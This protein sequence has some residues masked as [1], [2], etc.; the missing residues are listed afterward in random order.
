MNHVSHPLTTIILMLL[1]L[2]SL[3]ASVTSILRLRRADEEPPRIA[4]DLQPWLVGLTGVGAAGLYLYRW[5]GLHGRWQ[6]LYAHVD[7]LLLI[8]SLFAA[9]ILFIQWRPRLFGLSAFATPLLTLLLAWGICASAWTYRPFDL[10]TLHPV[11]KAVH[12]GGVYLGTL[13]A[14]VAA[15]AGGMYLYVQSRLKRKVEMGTLG[16]LASLET[17]ERLIVRASTLGFTL[18]TIG[19]VSGVVILLDGDAAGSQAGW[20]AWKIALAAGAW[21]VYAL[22]MNVRYATT[23]RGARAAWLSIAGLVLLLATYGVVTALPGEAGEMNVERRTSN[24]EL[25]TSKM[26]S[27]FLFDLSTFNVQRST[28]DVQAQ[29]KGVS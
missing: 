26:V 21:G 27:R 5:L 2:L 24:A 23:F 10:Q 20:Y 14:A 28:F 7:G 1:T 19:L 9:A 11:W 18:L 25:R 8:A 16:R 4:A 22:L 15:I 13:G 17:L 12:L 29:R 3:G 6:P